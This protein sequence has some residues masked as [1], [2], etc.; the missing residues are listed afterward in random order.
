MNTSPELEDSTD[1]SSELEDEESTEKVTGYIAGVGIVEYEPGYDYFSDNSEEDSYTLL[2]PTE[3]YLEGG[4]SGENMYS[5]TPRWNPD[6][7]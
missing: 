3:G 1:L 5:S 4:N 7:L 6:S 2:T